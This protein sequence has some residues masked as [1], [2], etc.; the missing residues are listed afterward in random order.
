MET[1]KKYIDSALD[2]GFSHAVSIN[3]YRL[4]CE[5]KIRAYCNPQQCTNYG[6]TWVCP[7]GCGTVKECQEKAEDYRFGILLQTIDGIHKI[8]KWSWLQRLQVKHNKRFLALADLA[9]SE[10][11]DVLPLTTGGCIVCRPCAF[12]NE[13]CREPER[14]MHSLSAYGINVGKLCE[15]AG[16]EYSFRE[17]KVYFTAYLG[18]RSES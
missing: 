9:R 18:I 2:M 17:D 10:G 15:K 5:S 1:Y 16:L 12:P 8:G 11:L 6:T 4:E 13:P 14:R 3:N 7:P